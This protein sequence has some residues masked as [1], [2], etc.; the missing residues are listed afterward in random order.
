MRLQ[1]FAVLLFVSGVARADDQTPALPVAW[2]GTW[3][4]KLAIRGADDKPTDVP[5]SLQIEP[6]PD[7]REFTWKITYGE[8]ER[9]SLRDYKLVPVADKPGRFRIDERNG[10]VLD[11][12]LVNQT[13]YTQFG[14]TGLILTARYELR[15]DTLLL[16]ITSAKPVGEKMGSIDVQGYDVQGVQT[17]VMRKQAI[18]DERRP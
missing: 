16:E 1:V 8:G 5:V 11:A 10:I 12:R 6:I 3:S 7:T 9:K 14:A 13:L 2:H 4:G 15:G 17:A 18:K